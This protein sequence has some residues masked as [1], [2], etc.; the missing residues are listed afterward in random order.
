MP[1]VLLASPQTCAV[2]QLLLSFCWLAQKDRRWEIGTLA[3]TEKISTSIITVE[4]G[5][6]V[7][8]LIVKILQKWEH[9]PGT[10]SRKRKDHPHVSLI[11]EQLPTL[12]NYTGVEITTFLCLE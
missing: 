4:R 1:F 12:F 6:Q 11:R 3:P 10:K 9:I 7:M 5:P 2:A 8:K